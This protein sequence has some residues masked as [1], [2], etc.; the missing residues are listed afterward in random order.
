VNRFDFLRQVSFFGNL[1]DEELRL[2]LSVCH[3]HSYPADEVIFDEGDA[4]D[5]F[6]IVMDGRVEVWKN[7]KQPDPDLLGYH[8]P[9]HFFGEMALV[10]E[11][12]RSATV[13]AKTGV[14]VLFLYRDDFRSLVKDHSSIAISVMT[15]MS[16]LVRISN[17]MYVEELRKRNA[18]LEKAN[19]E[20]REAQMER[21]RDERLST[22]GKFSSMI[23]HD[24]R[25]PISNLKGQISL[26][27]MDPG[28]TERVSRYASAAEA[29]ALKLER[30][31]A[32]F[33]DYSRGET[34]LDIGIV[35]PARLIASVV[36]SISWRLK[37][38]NIKLSIQSTAIGRAMLD[39]ERMQRALLNLVDNAR[40]ALL[41]VENRSLKL[42]AH[43]DTKY[44]VFEVEDTGIG[45]TTEIQERIFEPF[46]SA[47][48]RG[49]T[50]LGLV[51]VRNIVESHGGTLSVRSAPGHGTTFYLK[52][53]RRT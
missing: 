8:D 26:I 7:F 4:A 6:F 22:L 45:M 14:K 30:L 29:E 5:R 43:Y 35:E 23:L 39:Y 44:L 19:K 33:L 31:A 1:A 18:E 46:F 2:I 42:Y 13:T 21:L 49:G 37:A 32:E 11:L 3:E 48:G 50:G 40:K 15:S 47:S 25:N 10:D 52:V 27:Q 34:R 12:P 17:D 28:D 36:A 38:D 41:D 51:I 9:G 20:L 16:S 53:P 24:I